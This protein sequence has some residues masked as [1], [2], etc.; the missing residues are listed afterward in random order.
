MMYI[1][2]RGEL[3]REDSRRVNMTV[4]ATQTIHNDNSWHPPHKHVKFE[5]NLIS[6]ALDKDK[7]HNNLLSMIYLILD[8]GPWY[9]QQEVL[10]TPQSSLV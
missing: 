5:A 8:L 4:T 7:L 3:F 1:N 2:Y 6:L 9:H 10:D